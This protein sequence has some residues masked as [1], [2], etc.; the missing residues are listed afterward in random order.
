MI[1][2]SLASDSKYCRHMCVAMASVLE[3]A[4][5]NVCFYIFDGGIS[6]VQKNK[7][8]KI[9]KNHPESSISYLKVENKIVEKLPLV[10]KHLSLTAYHRLFAASCIPDSVDK[11]IYIDCDTIT[12]GDIKQF[13]D[14][15]I[16]NYYFGACLDGNTKYHTERTGA[17][18]Y[19]NSGVMLI[20]LKKWREDNL[21]QKFIDYMNNPNNVLG[22]PDQDVLNI[23]C[24]GNIK[25]LDP[26]WNYQTTG[27]R[28]SYLAGFDRE[29]TVKN[30]LHFLVRKPWRFHCRSPYQ[31]LYYK[32]LLKT[33][34][35][36]M[37][38]YFWFCKFLKFFYFKNNTKEF[39]S[40]YTVLGMKIIR[41][42][43]RKKNNK[44]ILVT[45]V[46][47]IPVKE[48]EI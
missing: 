11:L 45:K 40:E 47:G 21:E 32:Y 30:I 22:F 18:N 13:Y 35:F 10:D 38:P 28:H 42:N 44:R 6:D 16:S 33:P 4:S 39:D 12:V 20:N 5:D 36:Y 9:L 43:E 2:I 26:S 14:T 24:S 8:E 15:D 3:N 19:I 27:R 23:V 31:H 48:K 25:I 37:Y 7:V 41:I 1:N 46:F 34:W 29:D 17:P